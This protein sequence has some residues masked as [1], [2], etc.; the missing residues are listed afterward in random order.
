MLEAN[1][2]MYRWGFLSA[3]GQVSIA[4]GEL[5]FVEAT[6]DMLQEM[7]KRAVKYVSPAHCSAVQHCTVLYCTLEH[8]V[9]ERHA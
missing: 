6:G 9:L 2:E 1:H 4:V 7:N 3:V 8:H 5:K